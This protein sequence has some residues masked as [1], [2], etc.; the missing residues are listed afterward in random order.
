MNYMK[1]G[2]IKKLLHIIC[3]EGYGDWVLFFCDD[4][5]DDYTVNHIYVDDEGD[6]CLE[7]TDMEGDDN[8]D[9]TA[10]NVLNRIKKYDNSTYVYF[11]EEYEDGSSTG[12]DIHFKWYIG[13]DDYG[14]DILNI[15]CSEMEDDENDDYSNEPRSTI[16]CP[17]C[18]KRLRLCDG[19]YSCNR[20]GFNGD[21]SWGY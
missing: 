2:A 5:D 4:D 19:F 1:I 6:I 3:N 20:C 9:F 12:Y 11:L 7:S 21:T 8:Y 13:T 16:E 18:G 14:N 17:H 15:D 10:K